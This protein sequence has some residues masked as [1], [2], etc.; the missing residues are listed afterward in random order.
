MAEIEFSDDEKRVLVGK[1]QEYF[2]NEMDQ[3][4]GQFDAQF[5]L[6][7]FARE[8]GP[9]FYNRALS[10][11]QTVFQSRLGVI[12]DAVDLRPELDAVV[13]R[14]AAIDAFQF[15][16]RQF[17]CDDVVVFRIG[18]IRSPVFGCVHRS[19]RVGVLSAICRRQG[20]TSRI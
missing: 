6:D 17:P 2:D 20:I 16:F 14:D 19:W 15:L 10:D 4:I 13:Q 8:I 18:H 3:D 12:V 5:L 7:F 9:Y 11:A 1:I